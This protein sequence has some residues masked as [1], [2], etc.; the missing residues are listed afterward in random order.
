M[1]EQIEATEKEIKLLKKSPEFQKFST[2]SD[3]IS[4]TEHAEEIKEILRQAIGMYRDKMRD[5]VQQRATETF[6]RLT[7]EK[8][9]DRL[10][11]NESYGLDLIVD[12]T[13]VNRSAGA[14][15]I[16]AMSLIEAL[17]HHGRRRGNDYGYP[18]G[19]VGHQAPKNIC[20]I[21][22]RL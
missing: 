4:Q 14:E 16:V 18:S 13:R 9:F 1:D 10:E 3:V 22:L 6:G 7:T 19:Q 17:N 15:Q 21:Y 8:T 20:Y 12:G 2:T 5:D 11:I